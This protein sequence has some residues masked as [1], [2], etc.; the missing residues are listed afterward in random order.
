MVSRDGT[1]SI[2]RTWTIAEEQDQQGQEE[3]MQATVARIEGGRVY[4]RLRRGY[5]ETELNLRE[6]NLRVG[7]KIEV[8]RRPNNPY[9]I[10]VI[11][12]R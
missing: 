12:E 7:D 6:Y 9:L 4:V 8:T 2:S 11:E 10:R 1:K 5:R 3:R